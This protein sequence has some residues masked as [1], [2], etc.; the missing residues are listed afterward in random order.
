[1]CK[2]EW[3]EIPLSE[4]IIALD[5]EIWID[6]TTKSIKHKSYT[7]EQNLFLCILPNSEHSPNNLEVMVRS[8]IEKH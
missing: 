6:R 3:V 4:K 2:L 8:M 1:M 7:N 5:L